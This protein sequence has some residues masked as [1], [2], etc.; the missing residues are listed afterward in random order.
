L[1]QCCQ[2]LR[3]AGAAPSFAAADRHRIDQDMSDRSEEV[4]FL[5]DQARRFR[6]LA[7]TYKTGISDRLREMAVEFEARADEIDQR[8]C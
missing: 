8:S 3:S 4:R 1:P 7:D 2:G 6:E 5:R